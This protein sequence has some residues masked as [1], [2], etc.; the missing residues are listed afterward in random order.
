MK[1]D[2][3]NKYF[4]LAPSISAWGAYCCQLVEGAF[5]SP[6]ENPPQVS[7]VIPAHNHLKMSRTCLASIAAACDGSVT[8]EVILVDDAS[9]EDMGALST[10][11]ANLSLLRLEKNSGYV[12]ACNAGAAI[13]RGK[14]ILFLNNDVMVLPGWLET[15]H[16]A[17]ESDPRAAIVGSLLAD[18][19]GRVQEAGGLLWNDGTASHY[20]KGASPSEPQL[21]HLCEVDY[22]SGASMLVRGDFWRRTG[23]FDERFGMGYCEDADLAMRARAEGFRVLFQPDSRVIHWEH[24]TFSDK[25]IEQIKKNTHLLHSK[26]QQQFQAAHLP[27]MPEKDLHKARAHCARTLLPAAEKRA[28]G[29]KYNILYYYPFSAADIRKTGDAQ[30]LAGMGERFR[31]KGQRAVLVLPESDAPLDPA[32]SQAFAAVEYLPLQTVPTCGLAY[33]DN[34]YPDGLGEQINGLCLKH[35]VDLVIC[36]Y[37]FH[38]KLLEYVPDNIHKAIHMH[39]VLDNQPGPVRENLARSFPAWRIYEKFY[40]KRA[41]S[42]IVHNKKEAD[43]C[44]N[45]LEIDSPIVIPPIPAGTSPEHFTD[46]NPR[47]IWLEVRNNSRDT[48]FAAQC[49]TALAAAREQENM[50]FTVTCS[51]QPDALLDRLT[52]AEA[53][54]FNLPFV[55]IVSSGE[56]SAEKGAEFC[57]AVF[58]STL[59]GDLGN[60]TRILEAISWR[61]PVIATWH[62]WEMVDCPGI[63]WINSDMHPGQIVSS[64]LDFLTRPD[65]RH[66]LEEQ[67]RYLLAVCEERAEQGVSKLLEQMEDR[68]IPDGIKVDRTYREWIRRIEET[69]PEQALLQ[70]KEMASWAQPPCLC[71]LMTTW[72]TVPE[73]LRGAIDSVR[74][75]TYENWELVIVDDA[76]TNGTT[77]EIL[78][79]YAANDPRIKPV[80]LRNTLGPSLAAN[81]AIPACGGSHI[82]F[83]DHDDLLSPDAL[84]WV[85]KEIVAHPGLAIL[86]SDMD[87]LDANGSRYSPYFK[88]DWN[89]ELCLA[90]NYLCHLLVCRTDLVRQVGGFRP[91]ADGAQDHDLILRISRLCGN[92]DIRHIPRILYHWRHFGALDSISQTRAAQCDAARLWCV[93]DHLAAK[94]ENAHL[95]SGVWGFT[96]LEYA[97]PETLPSVTCIIP[98][99]DRAGLTRACLEGVLEKTEY[100]GLDVILVDNASSEESVKSLYTYCAD[101]PSVQIL[102]IDGAF[103]YSR[104]NNI[105][106]GMAAGEYLLFLNN[107]TSV[108]SPDWLTTMMRQAAREKVGAVGP[109]LLY[110]DGTIQH[111]G[112]VLLDRDHIARESFKRLPAD[113]EEYFAQAQVARETS[114]VTGAC[115]LVEKKKFFMAGGFDEEN[116]PVAYNDVDLC[117]RLMEAGF[118]NIYTPYATLIHHEGASRG[119]DVDEA[120]ILRGRKEMAYFYKRWKHFFP[121]RYYS[122]YFSRKIDTYKLLIAGELPYFEQGGAATGP[123]P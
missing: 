9:T 23:G 77:R 4:Q 48:R 105:A 2:V 121:D 110:P 101:K 37:S 73:Y 11:F 36:G 106:A 86:Y 119:E 116:L 122:P 24:K 97:L 56:I 66:A 85:A 27:P 25:A 8:Y 95:S 99:R 107:D 76:S 15:L 35:D 33:Q 64:I 98:F 71:V 52:P 13:A 84:Y 120:A 60:G 75:Q 32:L 53:A 10:S 79:E 82:A 51:L 45:I 80:F 113:T 65:I 102:Q 63:V 28:A 109:K 26:W 78:N 7:V 69:S 47:R 67:N 61:I 5:P 104:L 94:G 17:L 6:G 68:L 54:A 92:A 38:S 50:D 49:L 72:N 83:M 3:R 34:Y 29:K 62:A 20:A 90:Q 112:I 114:A 55:E 74:A 57:V 44:A 89:E 19:T 58:P 12:L 91:M 123:R 21:S 111:A 14:H 42:I 118:T 40:L 41:D 96:R 70:K 93:G 88:G 87:H 31:R 81:E 18:I 39:G 22:C 59:R 46:R 16:L 30:I 115:L 1:E 103:N 100:P 43:L 108:V 117:C